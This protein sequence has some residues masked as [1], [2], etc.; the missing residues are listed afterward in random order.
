MS[1][2][3]NT[4]LLNAVKSA[5]SGTLTRNAKTLQINGR[6]ITSFSLDELMRLEKNYEVKVAR[7]SSGGRAAVA[8]FRGIS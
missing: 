4:E 3:T 1:V 8:K 5:I 2:P 7:E 6:S